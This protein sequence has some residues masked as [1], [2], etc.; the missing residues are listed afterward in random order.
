MNVGCLDSLY[1]VSPRVSP[2]AVTYM[3]SLPYNICY[4]GSTTWW[5]VRTEDRVKLEKYI[6]TRARQ[7]YNVPVSVQ[8]SQ[9]HP[10]F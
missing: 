3:L 10:I 6:V 8:L 2:P 9:P 4:E 7:W 5:V 1:D